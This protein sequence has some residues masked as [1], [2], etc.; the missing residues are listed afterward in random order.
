[1]LSME[2]LF[3]AGGPVGSCGYVRDMRE[4]SSRLLAATLIIVGC[5]VEIVDENVDLAET[6]AESESDGANSETEGSGSSDSAE[7]D[8]GETNSISESED[9]TG[10]QSSDSENSTGESP[11]DSDSSESGPEC[12]DGELGCPCGIGDSCDANLACHEGLCI[13]ATCGDGEVSDSEECDDGNA[14]DSDGCNAN[15]TAT[16]VVAID[17]GNDFTCVLMNSG[18]A[19]CWGRSTY[20]QVGQGNTNIIGD[21]ETPASIPPIALPEKVM[22]IAA[23]GE[24]A[25]ALLASN[26]VVCW[27]YGG[28][29]RLGYANIT[30]IGDDELPA[31]VGTVNAGGNV[32]QIAL[33]EAH[34]C[35]IFDSGYAS[36]W[37][38]G[39]TYQLGTGD[40]TN[41]GDNEHPGSVGVLNAGMTLDRIAPGSSHTCAL[42]QDGAIRCWGHNSSTGKLGISSLTNYVTSAM[43]ATAVQLPTQVDTLAAGEHHTCAVLQDQQLFC[44]GYGVY[45][46]LGYGNT[47]TIGDN[48][49]P[50]PGLPLPPI[51]DV[52]VARYHTCALAVSGDVTCWGDGEYGRLGYGNVNLVLAAGMPGN[53]ALGGA[54]IAIAAGRDHSCAL[55]DDHE[56]LCWGRAQYGA[57]GHGTPDDVGDDETPIDA[58]TVEVF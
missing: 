57:L 51:V 13:S 24:H 21:A 4:R 44:W 30:N 25:C 1:M 8:S 36:C 40:N 12:V 22:A 23:G 10:S 26:N 42:R 46:A 37:G 47:N 43:S 9:S 3:S 54:A 41:I 39:G 32:D 34:T 7:V 14:I 52:A 11:E 49:H 45:G 50:G 28:T 35:V 56:V 58:G 16:K 31:A 53:V 17:A 20:G 48:E 27:G 55:R 6:G 5:G 15:C 2:Q 19:K 18:D 33:G 38:S 29:G